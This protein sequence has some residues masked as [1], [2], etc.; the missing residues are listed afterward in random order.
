MLYLIGRDK[1][2]NQRVAFPKIGMGDNG[3]YNSQL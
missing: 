3:T 2:I 1:L